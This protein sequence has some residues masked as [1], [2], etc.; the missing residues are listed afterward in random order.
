MRRAVTGWP[1]VLTS[2]ESSTVARRG[3]VLTRIVRPLGTL[4]SVGPSSPDWT[5]TPIGGI[6]SR[7]ETESPGV[8][9]TR[10]DTKN[11]DAEALK[12]SER[13]AL[14]HAPPSGTNGPRS[15]SSPA[16]VNCP[17]PPSAQSLSSAMSPVP[18]VPWFTT[19]TPWSTS[20][21]YPLRGRRK[22]NAS[23]G[24]SFGPSVTAGSP[25]VPIWAASMPSTLTRRPESSGSAA[26][27][28]V[29][30]R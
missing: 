20:A 7:I 27:V 10:A 12:V 2:G 22:S 8:P 25:N 15:R 26:V 17:S 4:A 21:S 19:R 6:A 28:V 1:T 14:C 18:A 30:S 3:E 13:S 29:G 24:P 16:P 23:T 5:W 11:R 9:E